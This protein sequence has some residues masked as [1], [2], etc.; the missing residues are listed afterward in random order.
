MPLQRPTKINSTLPNGAA[1]AGMVCGILSILLFW[2]PVIGLVL[3]IVGT[4]VSGK[5]ISDVN[6]EKSSGKGMAIAGLVC[7]IIGLVFTLP[8]NLFIFA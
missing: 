5:A 1:I 8:F 4:S 7:G 2:F 6:Q 3:A